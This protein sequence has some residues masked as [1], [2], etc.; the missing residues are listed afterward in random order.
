[1]NTHTASKTFTLP[2]A[3]AALESR[4]RQLVTVR[5][6]LRFSYSVLPVSP[7]DWLRVQPPESVGQRFFWS[8]RDRR[9]I[10]AGLGT[11]LEFRMAN[12]TSGAFIDRIRSTL[13]HHSD[14]SVFG[15]FSFQ[16]EDAFLQEWQPFGAGW[17]SLPRFE[18]TQHA[19]ADCTFSCHLF[20]GDDPSRVLD[21]LLQ[22]RPKTAQQDPAFPAIL[23]RNDE[24]NRDG[25]TRRIFEAFDLFHD[26]ILDKI[27]LARKANFNFAAS[28]DPMQ[29]MSRL[30]RST[31]L[32]Y[33]FCF[34]P[35]PGVSFLGAT[36]ERLFRRERNQLLSEVV[37]GT[38][39]RGDSQSEDEQLAEEMLH[40]TKDQ[41][42]HDIVRKSIRQKL[43][44][45]CND[46]HVDPSASVLKLTRK[47]H[48]YSA[49]KARI[50]PGVSDGDLIERLHPTP[51]VGGYPTENALPEIDRLEPFARGWYAAPVGCVRG[52]S[53]EF[54]VAIRSGLLQD[55][56][57]A[58]YSGAGIVPGSTP[59][60]EWQE[61]EYKIS[62]FMDVM[63]E[64]GDA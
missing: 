16:A 10:T 59:D 18:L 23:H 3:F 49:V 21:Q 26:E 35:K 55:H 51:A 41:L 45:Y 36:P 44:L 32:C 39:R 34:E 6:I 9:Q 27:V 4:L 53:A 38:R 57:L 64:G 19:E 8:P 61:I 7:L 12:E 42:E 22:L 5:E 33:H 54:A 58:L 30:A 60:E 29:L 40:S 37:A 24:P 48:L 52:D 11:G 1:M 43:H 13:K 31:Q 47:Q 2:E 14:L 20:P 63:R 28:V 17:F 46:L 25:W 56:H 50:R 15:G 62:D